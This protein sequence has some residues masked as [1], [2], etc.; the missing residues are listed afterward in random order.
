M[1]K[2]E[3]SPQNL[4]ARLLADPQSILERELAILR[5]SAWL[6]WP[7][8]GDAGNNLA[9]LITLDALEAGLISTNRFGKWFSNVLSLEPVLRQLREGGLFTPEFLVTG[10]LR[11]GPEAGRYV[12]DVVRFL[13]SFKPKSPDPRDRPV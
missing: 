4:V 13:L 10:D 8:N 2:E 1:A 11:E 5:F 3:W 7:S 9:L 12:A 6:N